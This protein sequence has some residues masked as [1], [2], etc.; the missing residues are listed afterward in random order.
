[1]RRVV[2]RWRKATW[3]IVV[4]SVLM[5]IWVIAAGSA[6]ANCSAEQQ[7][8][9]ACKAGETVGRGIGVTLV[10]V[11][12]VIGF[13]VLSLIWLMSRPKHRMCPR[14]GEDVKKG[15]TTCAKCGYDF[16]ALAPAAGP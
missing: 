8:R 13:I 12:W 2:P 4:F 10:V 15:V 14:C 11:L 5:L 16:A 9:G 6:S 1:M 3:A 7:Y